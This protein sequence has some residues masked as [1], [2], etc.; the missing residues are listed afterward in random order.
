[1]SPSGHFAAHIQVSI[2]EYLVNGVHIALITS[3]VGV[4]VALDTTVWIIVFERSL[5][6]VILKLNAPR[7]EEQHY[8]GNALL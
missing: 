3:V 4:L 8:V 5:K 6:W 2:N 1:M 7:L